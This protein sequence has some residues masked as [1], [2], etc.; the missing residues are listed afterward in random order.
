MKSR[1]HR[2]Y[3]KIEVVDNKVNLVNLKTDMNNKRINKL[4]ECFD[5][6]TTT[7]AKIMA[8]GTAMG[9]VSLI[10]SI[11]TIFITRVIG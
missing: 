1:R 7:I 8:V 3:R 5:R 9:L 6:D 10:V 11:I 4:A 2:K